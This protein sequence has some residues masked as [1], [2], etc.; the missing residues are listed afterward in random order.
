MLSKSITA[1]FPSADAL[2]T[3]MWDLRRLGALR[4]WPTLQG[5]TQARP[6]LHVSVRPGDASMARAILRRAGGTIIL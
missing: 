1:R 6:T 5:T 4:C 2:D 3:A